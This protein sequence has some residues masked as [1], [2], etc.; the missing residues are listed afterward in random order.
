MPA[1]TEENA[2]VRCSR[3]KDVY[4]RQQHRRIQPLRPAG[5]RH[6][7]G[8]L[9]HTGVAD[10]GAEKAA[11]GNSG[12][13]GGDRPLCLSQ[14]H[15]GNG[16]GGGARNGIQQRQRADGVRDRACAVHILCAHGAKSIVGRGGVYGE[17]F[18]GL[19]RRS[20]GKRTAPH[21]GVLSN[22]AAAFLTAHDLAHGQCRCV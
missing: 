19:H 9:R 1:R 18:T 11:C 17:L 22:G 6:R 21:G 4:K 10:T 12:V 8:D 3:W 14:R 13:I 20:G 7:K 15:A 5:G 16:H 2:S